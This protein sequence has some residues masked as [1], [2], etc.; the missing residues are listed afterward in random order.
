MFAVER[1]S[2]SL[3][4]TPA[5]K[6][7]PTQERNITRELPYT[8][9][10]TETPE[11]YV[12]RTYLQFLWLPQ[13]IMPLRFLVPALLR[14]AY[15]L[16]ASPSI[17]HT[18]MPHPLHMLLQTIL[19]TSRASA[20]KYHSR[21]SQLLAEE[22]EPT[23]AEE[24]YMWYAYHKDKSA[25]VEMP[26]GQDEYETH[27]RLKAD[28]LEK[29]EHREV[30]IQILLHFLLLSLKGNDPTSL[31]NEP[32]DL[33]A[34]LPLP[35]SLSPSKSK[36][37]K[38]RDRGRDHAPPAPA[39]PL[40]ERLESYMDKLAMWQ[41]MQTV[42]SSLGLGDMESA[43]S[44]G[45]GPE[46]GKQKDGRDWMQVFCED[47]VEPL[48]KDKLPELCA[49]FH[50]KLFPDAANS[51][52]DT[53]DLSPPVSPKA[54]NKRLKSATASGSST[55]S[56]AKANHDA[57]QRARSR[58]LS[59]SL[60]QEQRERSRSVS[61]GPGGLRKRAIVREVSMTTVFKGKERVKSK[62]DLSRTAS[63]SVPGPSLSRTQSQHR[64][65]QE[66]QPTGTRGAAKGTQG[67]I[68]VAATPTKARPSQNQSQSAAAQGRL[69]SLF[70]D[71]ATSQAHGTLSRVDSVDIDI[72][73]HEDA[74]ATPTKARRGRDTSRVREDTEDEDAGNEWTLSSSPD[75]LLSS[76][77]DV[78]LSTAMGSQDWDS[79]GD[80][81][82]PSSSS[83]S[84][85]GG[86][87]RADS[88]GFGDRSQ[89]R[90]LVGDTPTKAR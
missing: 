7:L 71:A 68:L 15:A 60:E 80:H 85:L 45:N 83:P 14:V 61:I 56:R 18:S 12:S 64:K 17:S 78:L 8:D 42:D 90:T 75:V 44:A 73:A 34:S 38:R 37:R 31:A 10:A 5:V 49:L 40:E 77:P 32:S 74:L 1:L 66:Q 82:P 86:F 58:S 54:V 4:T 35:P 62:A 13:S 65:S 88:L 20:Q 21:I 46:K 27:E 39:Q 23:D 30:Q 47:I 2:Y 79:H 36:K 19:L 33:A 48:F 25:D 67:T 89:G 43:N 3:P 50:S 53:L 57:V 87:G 76:S 72:G 22:T 63:V 16:P 59:M 28:W 81:S 84:D 55:A 6:W 11:E 41:L 29:M 70:G 24:E 26:E 52:T 69:R 51:D 9:S